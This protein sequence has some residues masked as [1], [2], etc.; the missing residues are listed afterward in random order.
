M[1]ALDSVLAILTGRKVREGNLWRV[2]D[3]TGN[4]IADDGGVLLQGLHG[5][6]LNNQFAQQIVL[7]SLGSVAKPSRPRKI[8]QAND[9]ISEPIA[10]DFV[11][12]IRNEFLSESMAHDLIRRARIRK[13]R[14]EEEAL[15]LMI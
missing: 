8:D 14:A 6:L 5:A 3:A 10:L 12:R 15:L 2:Y 1:S 4:E 9:E 13:S 11:N 7:A